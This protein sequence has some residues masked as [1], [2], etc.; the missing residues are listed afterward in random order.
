MTRAHEQ[1]LATVGPVRTGG[2]G[3]KGL[4]APE[5]ARGAETRAR[6]FSR[7]GRRDALVVALLV[8]I[9]VIAL[10]IPALAGYPL[11]TGDDLT[12]NYP[13]SVLSAQFLAHGHLPVYDPYLWSG[14]PLLA[15]ASAHALLPTTLLFTFLPH[16]SAWVLAEALTLAAGA[17]GGFVLLRRNCCRTL[18][19]ALGGAMFGFGGF[20]SSQI[21]HI[22]FVAASASLVWCLVALD[23]IARDNPRRGPA[24]ALVLGAAVA[25][26]ALSGS[27]DIAIDALVAVVV[28]GGHL[29]ITERGR[30]LARLGWAAAG[31]AAGL[32]A[33]AVQWIPTAEFLSVTERAH[34]SF[35]FAASGSVTPAELLISIVP[36]LLGGGPIGLEAYTGPYNLSELDAYCGIASLIAIVALL[37]RWRSEYAGR[38]RVWYLIGAIGVLLALGSNTA[39][40]HLVVHLP[41]VGEQRLPSRAL[42]LFSLASSMLLG[43]WVED[44][45][46]SRPGRASPFAVASGLVAPVVVVGLVA[47]TALSG[48][49]YAGL[50]Q[51]LAGSGWSLRAIAPYLVVTA[52][53]ALAASAIVILG[54]SWSRRRLA[55]AIAALVVADLILFTANQSSLAPVYARGLNTENPLQAQL[56]ARLGPGGRY[57]IVDPARAGGAA[58]NQVGAPDSNV[59]SELAS[60]QG[61]GSLT[62]APYAQATGTHTQDDLDP[63]ALATGV[64]DSLDVRVLLT[65]ADE[66]S[67]PR[68]P[69]QVF[70]PATVT[71]PG[72]NS[73]PVAGVGPVASP[74][75]LRAGQATTRWFGRELVTRT[76]TMKVSGSRLPSDSLAE[77]GRDLRL[78]AA[79]G[80]LSSPTKVR[81]VGG[82]PGTAEVTAEYGAAADTVGLT[83]RDPLGAPVRVTSLVVTTRSGSSYGLD[84]PLSA[85]LTAPHWVAAGM[86]GP[87]AVFSNQRAR[88]SF[89]LA[90]GTGDTA[91]RLRVRVLG[92]SPF[93]PTEEV[94]VTSAAP[95]TVARAVADIPGWSAAGNHDGRS[96]AIALH[97]DGLVQS[98][99]VPSGTTLVTF[100]YSA[101]G[102]RAGL[103]T[104]ASGLAAILALGLVAIASCRRPGTPAEPE[105]AGGP[106]G[107]PFT[108]RRRA[109]PR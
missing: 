43:H 63:A 62:W 95:A 88:G 33:G 17:I 109:A 101:P 25:C 41:V 22:D 37:G 79:N 85:Y 11:I 64:F 89:S 39:L 60:A 28:Y 61:Y 5:P 36:H 91:G 86:I 77:L 46:A 81:V 73:P 8:G 69:A 4:A 27:P 99:E 29:L 30:V 108:Q 14:A 6:Q 75:G 106:V 70:R 45:L 78:V 59:L 21:V 48:R 87:Y 49:P 20:V 52:V 19:A 55:S 80:G 97:R 98:F 93:T 72:L 12:Q 103:A 71:L 2:H 57:L 65:V 90:G 44:Q 92:S 96:G 82:A 32:A 107:P 50:L 26:I 35:A 34:V 67:V 105:D 31:G 68:S 76:V 58:L 100:T 18:A 23:G 9:P 16:L 66:L 102:L 3:G 47:A 40:E 56:A 10:S 7:L 51:A 54:P 1:E 53:M 24:W 84:G 74:T 42:I 94:V 38:W 15:G 104:S 83:L 13:L